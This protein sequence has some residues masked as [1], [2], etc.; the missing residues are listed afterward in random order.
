M[1]RKLSIDTYLNSIFLF[2][3]QCY[4]INVHYCN[5]YFKGIILIIETLCFSIQTAIIYNTKMIYWHTQIFIHF[6]T[7]NSNCILILVYVIKS[8]VF[9]IFPFYWDMSTRCISLIECPHFSR[10]AATKIYKE[11]FKLK[12]N[13]F[14]VHDNIIN[15]QNVEAIQMSINYHWMD[16]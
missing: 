10:K 9:L 5:R 16:N 8:N 2:K 3:T 1:A 11:K 6:L 14:N 12:K 13:L 4:D 15:R 7:F